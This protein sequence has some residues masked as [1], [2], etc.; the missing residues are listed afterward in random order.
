LVASLVLGSSERLLAA[1][2]RNP[3]HRH[4]LVELRVDVVLETL[5]EIDEDVPA[6][7]HVELAERSVS[8]EV[9]LRKHD[10]SG[11]GVPWTPLREL[12]S[13]ARLFQE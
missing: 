6:E 13:I 1:E 2:S 12:A 11:E 4:T 5:I 10:R 8:D 3:E 9:M 7:D